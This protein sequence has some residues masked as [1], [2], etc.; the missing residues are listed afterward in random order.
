MAETPNEFKLLAQRLMTEKWE[1]KRKTMKYI[2]DVFTYYDQKKLM[3]LLDELNYKELK[4]IA[5]CGIPGDAWRYS[6]DLLHKKK[7]E[8]ELFIEQGGQKATVTFEPAENRGEDPDGPP[9]V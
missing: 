2:K 3:S 4:M 6:V 1:V 7:M 9:G 5:G 8:L